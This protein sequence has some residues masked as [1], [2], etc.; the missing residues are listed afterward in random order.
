MFAIL[1]TRGSG[2]LRSGVATDEIAGWR[3]ARAGRCVPDAKTGTHKDRL[4]LDPESLNLF[5][6]F[7]VELDESEKRRREQRRRDIPEWLAVGSGFETEDEL[8]NFLRNEVELLQ[9]S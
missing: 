4:D 3:L 7:L 1:R 2:D 6:P 5:G 8:R 9:S